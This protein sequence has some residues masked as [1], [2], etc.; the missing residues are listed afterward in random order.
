MAYHLHLD[1]PSESATCE[2]P[3]PNSI[4]CPRLFN[5][6]HRA[7]SLSRSFKRTAFRVSTQVFTTTRCQTRVRQT[8]ARQT[9]SLQT[10]SRLKPTSG[11]FQSTQSPYWEHSFR[12]PKQLPRTTLTR[13]L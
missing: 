5:F 2:I 4:S 10:K 8:R 7:A 1:H 9:R 12:S 13:S 6:Y 11:K 3:L